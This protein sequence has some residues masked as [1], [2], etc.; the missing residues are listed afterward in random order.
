MFGL[1][2]KKSAPQSLPLPGDWSFIG[3]DIHSHFIPG[4]DDGPAVLEDSLALLT[5][6]AAGGFTRVVTT[7]H[8]SADYFPNTRDTILA[9]CD[10]LKT[11]MQQADIALQLDVAAEYMIDEQ[12]L[13]LLKKK[14]PLL[15][16]GD[17]YVL[18]EMGFVQSS[19]M[20]Q[21]ALF[22]LQARD[23]RPVLAHPERY[24]YYHHAP[25]EAAEKLKE[26]GCLL[27]LN[28]IA[29]SGYYGQNVNKIANKMLNGGFYSFVGSDIHH[30]KHLRAFNTILKNDLLIKLMQAP[31]LNNTI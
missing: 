30:A 19:P 18:V 20:L 22:E 24:N 17:R 9:G 12:F 13:E 3:T 26:Q 7:P 21:E 29:L 1:F 31:L 25:V 4:I 6:M 5:Q 2:K 23:Y 16:F 14:E 15:S 28:T 27:Q 8:V 10:R 11:A